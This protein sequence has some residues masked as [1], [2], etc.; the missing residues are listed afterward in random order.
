MKK[1]RIAKIVLSAVLGAWISLYMEMFRE[2]KQQFLT[3]SFE[4]LLTGTLST[5]ILFLLFI[6]FVFSF[7]LLFNIFEHGGPVLRY[8]EK[9][10]YLF[11]GILLLTCV[12]FQISGSSL[13]M[14]SV[15]TT[16]ISSSE[17]L[18]DSGVVFGIPRGIRADEW[19]VLTP[20]VLSQRVNG[21]WA[22]SEILRGTATDVTTT[23]GAPALALVG[24]FR[25]F[26][27]GYLIGN[28]YGL[29]F[30]W[31]GRLIALFLAS[32]E[33]AKVYTKGNKWFSAAAAVMIAFSAPVQWW[34]STN[35]F[36]D[37]LIWG[38]TAVVLFN[39]YI[40]PRIRTGKRILYALGLV[41]CGGAFIFTFYPAQ[42]V[43]LVY[44]FGALIIGTVING[45]KRF[46]FSWKRDTVIIGG[47][48][49]IFLILGAGVL[50]Q[51]KDT[52]AAISNTVYPGQRFSTGGSVSNL[53]WLLGWEQSF[54]LPVD[55]WNAVAGNSCEAAQVVSLFPLGVLLSMYTVVIRRKIDWPLILMA[56]VQLMF[57]VFLYAGF[58]VWLSKVSLLSN[59]TE[60]RLRPVM[61]YLEIFL[62]FRSL[63][64]LHELPEV[65][66]NRDRFRVWAPIL[67]LIPAFGFS[68]AMGL[69][70]P[71]FLRK[72]YLVPG[73]IAV[74]CMLFF[75]AGSRSRKAQA[76]F[77]AV[78]C[79]T[80]GLSGMTVN[81]L[82][83]GT[84]PL[85]EGETAQVIRE[86]VV[87]DPTGKW[88]TS[89]AL[90]V[91]NN[92]PVVFGAPTVTST[93]VYPAVENWMKLDPDGRYADIY[94]RYAH[95]NVSL[96]GA[97]TTFELLNPDLVQ[98]NL[99][100]KA[101]KTLVVRYV[102]SGRAYSQEEI[103][104][105]GLSY[106]KQA[107][108]MVLYAVKY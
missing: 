88:I 54:F 61:G 40:R 64:L 101:L 47:A 23:Y 36:V 70:D 85:E 32:Y 74:Y 96:N 11:G 3:G 35:G 72:A 71:A 81:P 80:V 77:L 104:A 57:V 9:H 107:G 98:L 63:C 93:N 8:L 26:Y 53:S 60:G 46:D 34:F 28:E 14:W 25:P 62:L 43:P 65:I 29:S 68:V 106:I 99:D 102:L 27:L 10:R 78:V 2:T 1:S 92:L 16:G 20:M 55:A 38:Q 100:A 7:V 56:I 94:N 17:S 66:R 75:L 19:A 69:F 37:M 87:G 33:C 105:F 103:E 41:E 82:Q 5:E 51:S 97:D 21:F 58:P 31:F 6:S 42:E 18:L 24:L 79:V 45:W 30:F 48:L 12:A 22:V 4:G 83:V 86:T 76:S 15:Y 52:V 89:E 44:I 49:V 50:Y 73:F 59:V 95:F 84:D 91:F 39:L 67:C 108:N 13:A 90:W